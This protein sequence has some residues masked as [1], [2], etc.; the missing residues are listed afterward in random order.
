MIGKETNN[1]EGTREKAAKVRR[2]EEY[3]ESQK[4]GTKTLIFP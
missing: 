1:K 4:V 2:K 3:K